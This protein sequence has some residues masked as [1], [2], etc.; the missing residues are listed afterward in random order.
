MYSK[1]IFSLVLAVLAVITA[2]P[3]CVFAA[4]S[5]AE[6]ESSEAEVSVNSVSTEVCGFEVPEEKT[7]GAEV[8]SVRRELRVEPS[9]SFRVKV[10]LKNT[11]SMPWF[12]NDSTCL[13][14]KMSL[15]TD[16][17]RDRESILFTETIDGVDDTNWEGDN[18]VGMDQLRV[19]PGEIASFTFW[20][21]A[22]D[23]PDVFKEYFTPVLKDIQWIDDAGFSFEVMVGDTGEDP[24]G[25]RTKLLY[26]TSSGSISDVNLDGERSILVDLS[27]QQMFLKLDDSVIKQF[28]VST[29]KAATPTPTGTTY[30]SLKQEVRVAGGSPHYIMPKF[31]MF[32]TG[33][34][35]I[36][37]LPSLGNDGGWFWTEARSH[38]GI[39]VSHGC[40]RL[41]PEDADFAYE[42]ADVGTKV[43]VQW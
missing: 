11:G 24:D 27:D 2:F 3:G 16:F 41:L 23:S 20:A 40:I 17:E 43:V 12:S 37:A 10:F 9:E 31:M 18:R 30:I 25:L 7:Y 29:G 35:G 21:L 26:L 39:P 13:G 36:H 34:Y 5:S 22:P 33:G 28:P 38:I 8:V 14:P 4:E 32:R 6:V 15:G 1:R 19:N 42:F